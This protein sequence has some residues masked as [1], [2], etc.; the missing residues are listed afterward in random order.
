V[1]GDQ[2]RVDAAPSSVY[3][4]LTAPL[5]LSPATCGGR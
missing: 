2:V 5:D 4:R 1:G 3:V